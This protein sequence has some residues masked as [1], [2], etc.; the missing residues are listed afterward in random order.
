MI[1]EF[2]FQLGFSEK[3][4]LPFVLFIPGWEGAMESCQF[5]G[6]PDAFFERLPYVL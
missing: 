6:F 1:S 4:S 3:D 5:Q 2:S